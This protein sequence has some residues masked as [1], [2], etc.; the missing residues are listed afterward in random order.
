ML[1]TKLNA[2]TPAIK[3]VGQAN[4]VTDGALYF[5]NPAWSPDGKKLAFTESK[6]QGIWVLELAT[7]NYTQVTDEASA[8]FGFQWSLDS[9]RILSRVAKFENKRRY[10]AIKIFNLE[11]DKIQQLSDYR[12]LMTGLPSWADNDEQIYLF[13]NKG[14]EFF[15]LENGENNK[16]PQPNNFQRK[17]FYSNTSEIVVMNNMQTTKFKHADESTYLNLALSPDGNKI[18]YE[19]YGGNMFVLDLNTKEKIDLGK[20]NRPNWSPDSQSLV[21]MMTEDDGHQFTKSDIYVINAD[22]SG[23]TNINNSGDLLEM[24]P[25][26]SPDGNSIVF[27]DY[28]SG[29]IY[30]INVEK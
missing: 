2:E 16:L 22:G 24:N 20:G 28:N 18:A 29:V 6:Y 14:L 5:M 21:Y 3:V 8:G 11:T 26:W 17:V 19:L 25:N 15:K 10:N 30:L 9:K 27:D 12:T 7:Q 4:A 13:S 23:K 1:L